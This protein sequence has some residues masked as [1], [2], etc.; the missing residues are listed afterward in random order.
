MTDLILKMLK[1]T[2]SEE[3][4][5]WQ[6]YFRSSNPYLPVLHPDLFYRMSNIAC[7]IAIIQAEVKYLSGTQKM[8]RT[9][10]QK[11]C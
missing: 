5:Y 1:E 3:D 4:P 8:E 7:E 2:T 9:T 10:T 6:F 11:S